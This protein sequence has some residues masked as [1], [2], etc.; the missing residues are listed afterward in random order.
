MFFALGCGGSIEP[1]GPVDADG[2]PIALPGAYETW[3]QIRRMTPGA[4]AISAQPMLELEFT[5]YLN[6]DTYLSFNLVALQSGGIVARGDA[7]YIMSTKTVR[8]TPRRALEPGFHYTVLLAAEDVRSVTASPLLLSP[9]S[10]RYV[11]DETLNPT[12]HPTRPEGRW[13]QVE[14]IFEARCASCHRDPQWQLNPLTFE[15]LVGKR[16]AQSEHL[17]VRPYDAPASYLMHKILPDYPLRRFTVQPPPWAPDNDPLSRE[18]LQ[19][20]ESWIRFGARSD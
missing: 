1:E 4:G 20:V 9:D 17:V 7:E 13:A 15:S 16:S 14:A 6:P 18:E 8:W 10:P 2:E 11:V 5:D 3:L 12:P 19:L